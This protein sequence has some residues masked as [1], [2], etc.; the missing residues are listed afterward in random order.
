MV[1]F[2]Q[3]TVCAAVALL[4]GSCV[5]DREP[6]SFVVAGDRL[7]SFTVTMNDGSVVESPSS[8]EGKVSVIAF[9]STTCPDCRAELPELQAAYEQSDEAVFVLIAREEDAA[10]IEAYWHDNGLTLPY[11][12][13]PD[14]A[15][16]N[17][18]AA[19]GIPRVYIADRSLTVAAQYGPEGVSAGEL[20]A[21]ISTLGDS[22]HLNNP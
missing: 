8:L 19:S 9:F 14:R 4:L 15:I 13:Q 1:Y 20:S 11:S 10:S 2:R 6:E 5:S 3:P 17:V 18:F 21:L 16:Y 12:A 22:S 7:P